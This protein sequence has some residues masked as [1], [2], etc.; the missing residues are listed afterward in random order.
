MDT[1]IYILWF[2][3]KVLCVNPV[4]KSLRH[5]R[6]LQAAT[7]FVFRGG[8]LTVLIISAREVGDLCLTR[9]VAAASLLVVKPTDPT[10]P[11]SWVDED[12]YDEDGYELEPQMPSLAE[13]TQCSNNEEGNFADA[14]ARRCVILHDNQYPIPVEV[15][16]IKNLSME[17]TTPATTNIFVA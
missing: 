5:P 13:V 6:E 1:K 17:F 12:L 11:L 10:P 7:S 3:F 4:T 14:V 16:V 8:R 2:M 9:R 15:A